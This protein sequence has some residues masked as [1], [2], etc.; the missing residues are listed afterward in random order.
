MKTLLTLQRAFLVLVVLLACGKLPTD[1]AEN[2]DSEYEYSK[3]FLD[4]FFIFRDQ[5]PNDLNVF[6]SPKLLYAS[7]NEPYTEYFNPQEAQVFLDQLNT[8]TQGFGIS[9]DST[10]TG[11]AITLV[12]ADSPAETA[13][14][15][16]GD[17][18][19]AVNGTSVT[20]MTLDALTETLQGEIGDSKDLVIGRTSGQVQISVT[21]GEF[22]VPSVFHDSL[23]TDIAYIQLT[24]FLTET[25]TSGGSSEEF[26]TALDLTAWAEYSI[27]DLRSNGGGELNQAITIAGEF[28]PTETPLVTISER[29]LDSQ[30]NTVSTREGTLMSQEAGRAQD[31]KFMVLTDK[32]TAS[33]SELL[34]SALRSNRSDIQIIGETTFGKAR[35]QVLS[36]TPEA[37]LAKVTYLAIAPVTGASYDL[38]GIIPDMAISAGQDALDIAVQQIKGTLSKTGAQARALRRIHAWQRAQ[39]ERPFIP[40]NITYNRSGI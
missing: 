24:T 10:A 8:K 40:L 18:L 19:I 37:G 6:S 11:F 12:L 14:L 35:G 29:V 23:D 27:F 2:L 33:A 20:G 9:V 21:I 1:P 34:V 13:G 25:G 26:R 4:A 15:L 30:T 39:P 17:I 7:V 22:Y 5:M 38:T 3:V 28:L 31:R 36:N 16:V 32:L